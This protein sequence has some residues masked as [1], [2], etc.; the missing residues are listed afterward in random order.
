[1][2]RQVRFGNSTGVFINDL[3]IKNKIIDFLFDSL[4]LSKFR[5]VMLNNDHQKKF[6]Y[7]RKSII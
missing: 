6:K 5:Y 3:N 1:M 2:Q 7:L 4:D